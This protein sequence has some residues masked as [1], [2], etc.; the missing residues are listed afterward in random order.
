MRLSVLGQYGSFSGSKRSGTN[1]VPG[2][3]C[4]YDGC[5]HCRAGTVIEIA[6]EGCGQVMFCFMGTKQETE[7]VT[8][9]VL[10]MREQVGHGR[11]EKDGR[12]LV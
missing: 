7:R 1:R 5:K 4:D 9:L 8:K 6:L 12:P 2:M 3:N 11:S 10:H